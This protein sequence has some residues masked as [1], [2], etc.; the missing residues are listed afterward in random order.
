[1]WNGNTVN[2]EE[3]IILRQTPSY[4]RL[5]LRVIY[6]KVHTALGN[7]LILFKQPLP[8][9]NSSVGSSVPTL[10]YTKED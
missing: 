5:K 3:D 8:A 4:R 10:G 9:A 1:M 2:G 6:N 7:E